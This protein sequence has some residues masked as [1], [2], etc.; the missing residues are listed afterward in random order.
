MCSADGGRLLQVNQVIDNSDVGLY[1]DDGLGVLRNIGKPEIERRKKRIIQ[2]FKNC[3][4]GITIMTSLQL[5]QYL[6]VE[7]DVEKWA[8]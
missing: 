3:G 6:D 8:V 5:V 7:F 2:I 1:R 4:L